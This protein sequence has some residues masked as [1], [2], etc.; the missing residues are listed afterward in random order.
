MS[1]LSEVGGEI[2]SALLRSLFLH[3]ARLYLSFGILLKIV[4]YPVGSRIDGSICP[5][6]TGHYV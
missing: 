2:P 6:Y 4:W 5:N 1:S 3:L